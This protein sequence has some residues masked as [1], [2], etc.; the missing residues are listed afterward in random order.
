MR[1]LRVTAR[2]LDGRV[3]TTDLFLP[4]DGIMAAEWIRRER[5][6]LFYNDHGGEDYAGLIYPPLPLERRG[7]GDRWYYA[8]SFAQGEPAGE[9]V[10]YWHRRFDDF[11]E[12]Y[13]DLGRRSKVVTRKGPY[14]GYRTPLVVML[15]PELTWYCVGRLED[16]R[17]LL[18]GVT[19]I[20]KKRSQGY[21]FVREW[22]VEPWPEDLSQLRPLPAES[23]TVIGIRPPYWHH[24]NQ[25]PCRWGEP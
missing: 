3:A 5:P 2:M 22:L 17:E 12:Q 15:V 9:Y 10:A 20:G 21:G 18:R 7:A 23:G 14:K 8:C 16:I 11:R 19:A 4:L 13:L 1:P 24:K 6:D 25:F